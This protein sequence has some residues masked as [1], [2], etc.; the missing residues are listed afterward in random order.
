M[1]GLKFALAFILGLILAAG[2]AGYF[3]VYKPAKDHGFLDKRDERSYDAGAVKNLQALYVALKQTHDSD[4]QFPAAANWMDK[5]EAR[6][7][8]DDMKQEEADKKLKDPTAP[9]QY[10]Y[11]INEAAAGKYKDDIQNPETTPLIYQTTLKGRNA[12][13]DPKKDGG[14]A[15]RNHA[16]SVSGKEI[17][18]K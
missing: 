14:K 7:R 8:P 2:L 4:G 17:E 3:F 12:H 6:I 5:I 13:G 18:L 1:K 11:A 16:I 9:D 15:P 10:G